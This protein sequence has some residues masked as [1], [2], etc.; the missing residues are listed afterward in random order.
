MPSIAHWEDDMEPESNFQLDES[1]MTNSM[2]ME[3]GPQLQTLRLV[4]VAAVKG[5]M[6]AGDELASYETEDLDLDAEIDFD[7]TFDSAS[8]NSD[9]SEV[10][11]FPDFVDDESFQAVEQSQPE[12]KGSDP[13][14]S[15][16]ALQINDTPQLPPKFVDWCPYSIQMFLV[17]YSCKHHMAP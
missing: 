1:P 17:Y 12:P 15:S 5:T 9:G 7:E 13:P 6:A 11:A 2:A 10:E 14:A 8:V 16:H 3:L 4:S